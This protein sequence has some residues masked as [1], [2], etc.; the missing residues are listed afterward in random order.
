MLD[1]REARKEFEDETLKRVWAAAQRFLFVFCI[2]KG[3]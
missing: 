3:R 1:I 2:L